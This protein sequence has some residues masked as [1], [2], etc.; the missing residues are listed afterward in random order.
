L[1]QV[2]QK[3]LAKAIQTAMHD[4]PVR[5]MATQIGQRIRQEKGLQNA[6]DIIERV[7]GAQG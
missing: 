7:A 2:H 5:R 4:M 1:A 3:D 6:I